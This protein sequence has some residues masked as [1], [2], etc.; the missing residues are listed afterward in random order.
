MRVIDAE[1]DGGEQRISVFQ[2]FLLSLGWDHPLWS[3]RITSL[4]VAVG[5]KEA[6]S[7]ILKD[8]LV[9]V[10]GQQDFKRVG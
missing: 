8:L 9:S 2:P 10:F 5:F 4:C 7:F 3:T 6:V 1:P